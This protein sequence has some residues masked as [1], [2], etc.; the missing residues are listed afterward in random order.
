ME[1][2]MNNLETEIKELG[3]KIETHDHS[4]SFQEKKIHLVNLQKQT[5]C[6]RNKARRST[7][8]LR[9]NAF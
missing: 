3:E 2:E 1:T 6:L 8:V 7:K 9:T 4:A 5:K